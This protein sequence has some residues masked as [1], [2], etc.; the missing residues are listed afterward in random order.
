[1]EIVPANLRDPRI[2]TAMIGT[3]DALTFEVDQCGEGEELALCLHGFPE[4]S[5]SWRYQLP[6]LADLGF[7]VWAPNLRGY[8]NS[9]R[10]EGLQAYRLDELVEDVARLIEASGKS[11]VT[12]IA[13]DWGA[14]IAWQFALRERLPLK[15]LIICNVP[16]P[17]SYQD[18]F[19]WTQL[20]KSWYA[21]FFQLPWLPERGMSRDGAKAIAELFR[22]R[23]SNP[24]QFPTEVR[25]VYRRNA[26]QPGALT[27]MVNYYRALVRGKRKRPRVDPRTPIMVPTLMVWGEDDFALDKS[28]TLTTG[29]YVREFTMRYLPGVSHW[30]QQ[31]QPEAVN[32]MIGAFIRGEPVP[33]YQPEG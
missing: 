27:A 8:G 2:E 10:P 17:Q 25:E 33:E 23:S 18:A 32:A 7:T 12:L 20:K 30:V 6:M 5:F 14:V 31:E 19:G 11:E 16:H 9:S 1:M 15:R 24:A 13:H 26:A 21:F 3:R 22:T 29:D 28:T 4:H